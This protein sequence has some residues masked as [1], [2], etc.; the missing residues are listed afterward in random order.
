M[1]ETPLLSIVIPVLNESES[2]MALFERVTPL[3]DAIDRNWEMLF[4][5]DGS[6]DDTAEQLRQRHAQD[7]RIKLLSF[8]RN[9]GKEA[10]LTAG[11]E[12]A[13]GA[14]VIPMDVDLQ[15][16]PELIAQM[17]EQWR[18]G[19]KV[20]LATR[21]ER[22]E[23]TMVKRLSAEGFY[24]LINRLSNNDIP[25][26]TGDFRLMDRCV[27]EA[28][29]Q[30]PE[31]TRFM[32]GILS[33]PGFKTTQVFYDRPIRATGESKFGFRKLWRLALD[34]VFSFSTMPLRVWTYLGAMISLFSFAYA[35]VLIVR[36][37]FWGVDTP[38]YASIMTVVL[39]LGGVQLISLG[40]IGEYV[41]RIYRETKQRPLYVVADKV[42]LE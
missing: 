23:D 28:V 6:A 11:I 33:W 13:T 7:A 18:D 9:F 10:A 17:V 16:P 15:D 30:M 41:G 19:Y 36:T 21:R 26:N 22:K 25:A 31:R 27:V 38:G 32:K 40:V 4:V 24:H 1:T 42:G 3:L 14:C 35:G 39:F 29:K 12:L 2:L 20:V 34:G 5:D 37:I 8:S